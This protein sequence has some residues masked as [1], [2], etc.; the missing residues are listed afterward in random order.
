M[1]QIIEDRRILKGGKKSRE[2]PTK[3]KK[4]ETDRK[5]H[6]HRKGYC[7]KVL[8]P[9]RKLFQKICYLIIWLDF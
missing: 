6:V 2:N 1:N 8:G 5:I 7:K 4:K 3:A 9:T